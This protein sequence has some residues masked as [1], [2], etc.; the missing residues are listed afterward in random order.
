M[1]CV[2]KN[3]IVCRNHLYF[4]RTATNIGRF[5]NILL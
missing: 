3:Q 4:T 1:Y 2:G 5:F